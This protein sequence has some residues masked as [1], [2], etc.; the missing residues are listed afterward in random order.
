MNKLLFKEKLTM[1]TFT[2][3]NQHHKSHGYVS[4]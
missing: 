1:T 2:H 3:E 4:V